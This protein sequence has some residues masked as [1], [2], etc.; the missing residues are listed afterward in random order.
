MIGRPWK[1]TLFHMLG[2]GLAAVMVFSQVPGNHDPQELKAAAPRVFIDCRGCDR[3]FIRT[4]ITFVNYVRDREQADVHV[5][6]TDQSTG[7]GGREYT[8]AFIGLR[9]FEGQDHTLTY[10]SRSTDTQDE[11]R[12]GQVEVL[13]RGLFPY[14]L[15]TPMADYCRVVFQQRLQPTHVH[16]PWDFWVFRVGADGRL[17]GEATQTSRS[18]DIDVSANRVTPDLKIRMSFSGEFEEDSYSYEDEEIVS[19]SEEIDFSGMAVKSLGRHWSAGGWLQFNS[20]TYS[21]IDSMYAFS[22][23]LEY[24]FFPYSVST[25]RQLRCLYKIGFHRV[26][27]REETIYHKT[28]ESLF[29]QSLTL[30]LD[31]REPWGSVS[32]SLEGSHYLHDYHKNR[33]DW[34]GYLSFRVFRGLSFNIWGRYERIH[35]QLNLPIGDASLDEVLLQRQ[36]LATDYDYS[37]SVG[38]SYTFGSAFSNVVNPRF[39]GSRYGRGR[40]R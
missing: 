8:L 18:L 7:S 27:Y 34:N 37:I 32:T 1:R 9:E 3:D 12:R 5:L 38:F 36:E 39:G 11:T 25:R 15:Q 30:A 4:E 24:N 10:V 35:D 29:N 28:S 17:S 33:L 40:W 6:I 23:A 2:F 21:N 16:D 20:E 13:K 14:I 22:P 26:D 19:K 31:I